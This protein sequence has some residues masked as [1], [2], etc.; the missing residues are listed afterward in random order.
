VDRR[1]DGLTDHPVRVHFPDDSLHRSRLTVLF[2]LLLALPHLAWL[3]G[4][5]A[6]AL[7]AAPLAWLWA[8]VLGRLPGF[9]HRFLAS[10]V[11]YGFH[12]GAYVHLAAN[13]FPGF[14][15]RPGYP[16]DL[17]LPPTPDRQGRLPILLRVVLAIPAVVVTA[18][19]ASDRGVAGSSALL[20][21][22]ASLGRGRMPNGLRDAGAYGLGYAAQTFAYLF[23]V[24][25]RYPR[26]SPDVLG[27]AWSL[28]P[29][30]VR[31]ELD[32][33]GRRSRVIVL[34]RLLLTL[35]HVV[36]L[37][38]WLVPALAALVANWLVALVRGRPAA[39]LHRFQS[40]F[41]RY[42][43]HVLS[44]LFLVT[45]P[46]PGF[47]GAAGYPLDVTLPPPERQSR[48]KTVFRGLLAVPAVVVASAYTAVLCAVGILGWFASAATGQMPPGLRD[49]GAVSVRY[50][51]Q[52]YAYASLLTD[53][54]PY[55][56]PALREPEPAHEH[57]HDV[58]GL[59]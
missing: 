53:R 39:P 5:T 35:P 23:L 54:Y 6:L 58:E 34:F 20:G 11:R 3:L 45:N 48:W 32:D 30:V 18:T 21:W 59:A 17:A 13:P 2:R 27:P 47:T 44:F 28:P 42:S 41:V 9:L 50:L 1:L 10:W 19:L 43:A 37:A 38:L 49:L 55:A 51:S 26:S 14:V 4:W 12:V 29:H 24:T 33:D 8:L 25:D 15:G 31:L 36:W 57:E 46:F 40:A 22:F 16:F 56:S 52:T 7:L